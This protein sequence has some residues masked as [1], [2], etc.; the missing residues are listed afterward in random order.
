[1]MI[2]RL[3]FL[4]IV[5][6]AAWSC[7]HSAATPTPAPTTTTAAARPA[8]PGAGPAARRPR[9]SRDSMAKARAFYVAQVLQSIAGH[10][11]EPAERV[12]KNVQVLKGITAAQL[13]HKMDEEY[14]AALSFSCTNCHR[15]N[16]ATTWASDTANDKRRARAMQVMVNDINH[17][18][19][20]KLYPKDT[21]EANCMSCH[22][23]YNEPPKNTMLP[24]PG[25]PGAP[26]VPP[27]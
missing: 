6:G 22:R 9:P 10:E 26:P 7:S 3:A 24:A 27:L 16:V 2:R 18:Y 5:A 8:T 23:G 12:F 4:G 14:G 1:M 15:L 25:Q 11:N 17:V 20:P 19:L 21:P 13:V